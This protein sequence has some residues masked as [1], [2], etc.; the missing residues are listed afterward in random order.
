MPTL[1]KP[2][3]KA[4]IDTM[5]PAPPRLIVTGELEV[6]TSGWT[7]Q[8]VVKKPQGFNQKILILEVEAQ[9]PTGVVSQIVQKLPLRYQQQPAAPGSITQV[10]V[11]YESDSVTVNVEIVN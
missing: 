7:G 3:F 6:P 10:T 5:P 8:L 9:A 1:L 4:W 2:T 11:L